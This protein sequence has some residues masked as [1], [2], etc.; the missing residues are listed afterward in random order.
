MRSSVFSHLSKLA[1]PLRRIMTK[2]PSPPLYKLTLPERQKL[3]ET[4]FGLTPSQVNALQT[5]DLERLDRASENV[6][7][8]MT[9]P[10]SLIVGVNLTNLTTKLT[11]TFN[12]PLSTEEP[13]VVAGVGGACKIFNANGGVICQPADAL[14]MCQIQLIA[15][16]TLTPDQVSEITHAITSR[17]TELIDFAN[18]AF[19]RMKER[20][21]G[22]TEINIKP[23]PP[24]KQGEKWMFSVEI[25]SL[26]GDAQG[27]N[28]LNKLAATLAQR[29]VELTGCK[30]GMTILSNNGDHRLAT[31]K[32]T[33]SP[34]TLTTG[35]LQGQD[36][37]DRLCDASQ[38]AER[39]PLRA[40]THNKGI[41][42]G[43]VALLTA[44]DEDTRAACVA[45]LR[46]C[47]DTPLATWQKDPS[48]H[49]AGTITIPTVAGIIGPRLP[50]AEIAR[51][52]S[53]VTSAK[54]LSMLIATV[55]LASNL[56]ALR[57]LMSSKGILG[58]HMPFVQRRGNST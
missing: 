45:I 19:P 11:K 17:H 56:A 50:H 23:L 18:D 29:T 55:G 20:C 24:K 26:T 40:I 14:M 53:E 33:L 58:N 31:A 32:V 36:M 28:H 3:L 49:L 46:H 27:A 37:L 6:V 10:L 13:S 21:G 54:E 4:K 51:H 34:E 43:V 1:P 25:Y 9:Q 30:L 42:N 57:S 41:L 12:L 15:T 52:L 16:P 39:D 2:P 47:K 5:V 8:A 44:F 35:D 38:F 7:G 22:V 48:G